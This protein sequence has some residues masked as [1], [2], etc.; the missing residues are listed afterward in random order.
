MSQTDDCATP[1]CT[2]APLWQTIT[3][4]NILG[5]AAPRRCR[6]CC[7]AIDEAITTYRDSRPPVDNGHADPAS[8]DGVRSSSDTDAH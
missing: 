5:H 1:G 4:G 8:A 7:A 3:E 2:R 6:V